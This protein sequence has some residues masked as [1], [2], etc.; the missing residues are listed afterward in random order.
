[1]DLIPSCSGKK[2]RG[3]S[4]YRGHYQVGEKVEKQLVE[5][6]GRTKIHPGRGRFDSDIAYA[7]GFTRSDV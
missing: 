5:W 4:A 2:G 1:M 3:M 7:E 6:E